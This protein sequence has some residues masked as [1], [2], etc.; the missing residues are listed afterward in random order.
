MAYNKTDHNHIGKIN[1]VQ[2]IN[3]KSRPLRFDDLPKNPYP[4]FVR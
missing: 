4:Q 2:Q 3:E 1:L